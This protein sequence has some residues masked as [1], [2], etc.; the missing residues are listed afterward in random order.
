MLRAA[1]LGG[2]AVAASAAPAMAVDDGVPRTSL[3]VAGKTLRGGA[4]STE[5]SGPAGPNACGTGF[6]DGIPTVR[7][8]VSVERGRRAATVLFRRSDRPDHVEVTVYRRLAA[9][10]TPGGRWTEKPV[11]L[12]PVDR[13][14]ETVAW[15]ATFSIRVDRPR[16][17]E[18]FA[19]WPDEGD[20]CGEDSAA[21]VYDGIRPG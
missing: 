20:G 8:H 18:S 13:D 12:E 9:D 21:Y 10:R 5:E 16:Y 3:E 17:V 14:G 19:E 15:S 4:W 6:G 1:I 2:L 7:R 11:T